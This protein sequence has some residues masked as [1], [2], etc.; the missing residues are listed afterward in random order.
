MGG[1][2]KGILILSPFF[3]PNIG[4]VENYLNDL[5]EYLRAHEYR[6]YVLT[7]QPLTTKARGERLERGQNLE[8]R[9]ISWPGYNLFHK[10]EP[11]PALEFIYLAPAL[12]IGAFIFMFGNSKRI[13]VIHAN[14]FCAAFIGRF[15]AGAFNKRSVASTCAVYNLKPVSFFSQVIRWTLRKYDK[16]LALGVLSKRELASIGLDADKIDTY[17]LWVNQKEYAPLDKKEAKEKTGLSARFIVLYVGRFIRIKGVDV[18]ME[19]AKISD[20]KITFVFIGDD[21]PYL[22][23]LESA[24]AQ[25]GNILLVKGIRGSQLVPYYQAS[26]LLV[27]PSQYEEAF[28]KVIIEALS[29]GTPVVGSDRGAIPH[30][31]N[32]SVGRIVS[33]QP[34]PLKNEIEYLYSHPDVLGRLT[35][36]C[37]AYAQESFGENNIKVITDSYYA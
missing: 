14:G 32:P 31:V 15:L 30:I 25:Y 8:I 37:R 1:V 11:Y 16:I 9:R 7:Y 34:G 20:K 33:A 29:C 12:F 26:D 13:D 27:V 35:K 2:K 24:A 18:L 4:G 17:S 19:T 28:G 10:L 36:N 21:G 23:Q 22:R 5:C 6:V 3:R